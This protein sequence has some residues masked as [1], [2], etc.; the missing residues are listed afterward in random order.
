M[1]IDVILHQCLEN[2]NKKNL[3]MDFTDM[4]FPPKC[5]HSVVGHCQGYGTVGH[6]DP[7]GFCSLTDYGLCLC[8]CS[9]GLAHPARLELCSLGLTSHHFP[10]PSACT[11]TSAP[12]FCACNLC[13]S[14]ME[15]V[16]CSVSLWAWPMSLNIISYW[17]IHVLTNGRAS[18]F[19]KAKWYSCVC[20][21]MY[22][23]VHAVIFF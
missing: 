13:R 9:P 1:H 15:A 23:H 17:S 12:C 11:P 18:F 2:N 22:T 8:I 4:I 10:D 19:F 7:T 21:C 5:F 14:H 16:S 3:S 20:M 6:R